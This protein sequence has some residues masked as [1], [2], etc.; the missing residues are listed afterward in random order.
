MTQGGREWSGTGPGAEAPPGWDGMGVGAAGAAWFGRDWVEGCSRG[1]RGGHLA[2]MRRHQ[3]G[4]C[5]LSPCY[6]PFGR[7]RRR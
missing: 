7:G 6:F 4:Q 5:P 1:P 2:R 3:P